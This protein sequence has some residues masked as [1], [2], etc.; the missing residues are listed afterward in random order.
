MRKISGIRTYID[1]HLGYILI[2]PALI[3]IAVFS[4]YP[5]IQS[6]SFALFDYQVNDQQKNGMFFQSRFNVQYMTEKL[7]HIEIYYTYNITY[8]L[9][10]ENF[11]ENK[12]LIER[13]ESFVDSMNEKYADLL[14]EV[15]KDNIV[16]ISNRDLEKIEAFFSFLE[17]NS[18]AINAELDHP[19]V[20]FIEEIIGSLDETVIHNN[21]VGLKNF[22]TLFTDKF[23][24]NATR[25]T[26]I[27][28]V[29]SVF[30]EL[31]LGLMLALI[32]NQAMRGRGMI[33][34][35]SL[36]PWAIPTSV[37]AMM[38]R[39]LYDGDA[40][41][42]AHLLEQ[43]R[44][45]E[46]SADITTQARPALLAV[47]FADVWKTTPYM[48]LLLLAGLQTI[49]NELYE[50]SSIDGANKLQQFYHVTLPLL[51]PSILVALLFRTLD[52]FRVHD[53]IQ[54]FGGPGRAT[55]S[56]SIYSYKVMRSQMNY[57]YGAAI[58]LF[59]AILVG[60]ISFIYIKVLGVKVKED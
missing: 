38:W 13:I 1:R 59:M 9:S 40:G 14:N 50:S 60:I 12:E 3:L 16:R 35:M 36:I 41:F 48:A 43:L 34:T 46:N 29:V 44:I 32:M 24:W 20:P 39:Y 26:L 49:P 23:L 10:Q 11:E 53:L 52:A 58:V 17:T 47:I 56:L 30:F 27:F 8:D 15:G 25:N 18:R 31:V 57:G 54:V 42:I 22:K 51:K 4:I 33:R 28:T 5:I 45:V 2:V 7:E 19:L 37:A 55:E 6:L 21:F